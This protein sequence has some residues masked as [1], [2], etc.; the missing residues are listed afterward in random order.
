MDQARRVFG[1]ASDA[2]SDFGGVVTDEGLTEQTVGLFKAEVAKIYS[3]L[4]LDAATTSEYMATLDYMMGEITKNPQDLFISF[5]KADFRQAAYDMALNASKHALE[6]KDVYGLRERGSMPSQP[7]TPGVSDTSG[8]SSGLDY[9]LPSGEELDTSGWLDAELFH[10]MRNGDLLSYNETHPDTTLSAPA[11]KRYQQELAAVGT[12]PEMPATDTAPATEAPAVPETTTGG[13]TALQEVNARTAMMAEMGNIL[14]E[15][16]STYE[17]SQDTIAFLSKFKSLIFNLGFII[18]PLPI[19]T[20]TTSTG[21][22]D[23]AGQIMFIANSGLLAG[24]L[25]DMFKTAAIQEGVEL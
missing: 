7:A 12:P 10:F 17:L 19:N 15:V 6:W 2:N 16:V 9:T 23:K 21:V 20:G 11:E 1:A 14:S 8:V 13:Q 4:G 25:L 3:A 22:S 24:E 5:I 18:D